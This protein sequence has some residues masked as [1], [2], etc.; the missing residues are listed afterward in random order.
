M[1]LI[2]AL[3]LGLI[4]GLTEFLPISSSGHL[5]IFQNLLGFK[6]PL[7]FFYI[8][9]HLGSLTSLLIY[10][11]GDIAHLIRDSFYGF[12][13]LFRKKSFGEI[14]HD[15]PH[16]KETLGIVIACIPAAV[17][18]TLFRDWFAGLFGSLQAVG[19]ALLGTTLLLTLTRFFQRNEKGLEQVRMLDFL[20]IGLFQALAIIPGISRSGATIAAGLFLG[21]KREEAFRFS[22]LLAVPTIL[23]AAVIEFQR[24]IALWEGAGPVLAVGFLAA[25]IVG[26]LALHLLSAVMRRGELHKFALYTLFLGGLILFLSRG[27][28]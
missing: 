6:E 3:L 24:G 14:L 13:F 7:L 21:W 27:M 2:E 9:V 22:F 10:F 23:G 4:Q 28:A 18:G 17:I 16:A 11:A 15:A 5:V 12:F 8:V 20:M 1:N 26:Y 19:L 25:A